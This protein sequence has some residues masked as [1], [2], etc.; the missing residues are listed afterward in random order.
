MPPLNLG[1]SKV[2]NLLQGHPS[3]TVHI[4]EHYLASQGLTSCQDAVALDDGSDNLSYHNV[5][6][7]GLLP[8]FGLFFVIKL[9]F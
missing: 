7:E 9:H 3:D 4:G 8:V 5:A 1:E 6:Q 2:G